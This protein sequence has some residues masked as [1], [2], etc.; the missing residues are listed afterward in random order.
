MFRALWAAARLQIRP[1]IPASEPCRMCN[2]QKRIHLTLRGCGL[3]ISVFI[4]LIAPIVHASDILLPTL[5][6]GTDVFTNVTVYQMNATDIFV[7]H[8]RGFGNAK[9]NT[10]DDETL[11]L[12]GLKEAKPKKSAIESPLSTALISAQT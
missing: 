11:V 4:A 10:L 5:K 9:I 7:R 6:I 12:L 1:E 3:F 2:I 8:N